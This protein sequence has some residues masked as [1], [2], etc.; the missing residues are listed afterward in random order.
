MGNSS[1]SSS[2]SPS[3]PP[4]PDATKEETER[5]TE[6]K[7]QLEK[8]KQEIIPLTPIITE[9]VISKSCDDQDA[10]VIRY[11]DLADKT[12]IVANIENLFPNHP[13]R[14]S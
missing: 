14:N 4:A 12:K 8:L 9:N 2:S 7:E 10:L 3:S 13:G 11:G 6:V 1:S 5:D